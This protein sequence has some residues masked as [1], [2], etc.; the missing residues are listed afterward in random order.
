MKLIE[1]HNSDPNYSKDKSSSS[2]KNVLS[3]VPMTSVP[4]SGARSTQSFQ[5]KSSAPIS[6]GFQHV[7][8]NGSA[9][10]PDS[11]DSALVPCSQCFGC[12]N[13]QGCINAGPFYS[14]SNTMSHGSISSVSSV[15]LFA[16]QSPHSP[17]PSSGLD[18]VI[19]QYLRSVLKPEAF[20][21]PPTPSGVVAAR[22]SN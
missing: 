16:P 11:T 20:I 7:E 3:P 8:S 2:T 15:P 6:Q 17:L 14:Y 4:L 18:S 19:D 1:Q 9:T 12:Q 22:G 21:T 13:N 10:S 5:A